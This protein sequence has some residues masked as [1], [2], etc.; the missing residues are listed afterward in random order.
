MYLLRNLCMS[1][2]L[3]FYNPY[4]NLLCS[5]LSVK[6]DLNYSLSILLRKLIIH[7]DNLDSL[8][9]DNLTLTLNN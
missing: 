3:L 6:N 8:L 7:I 1:L 9:Y 5:R 2:L 4:M